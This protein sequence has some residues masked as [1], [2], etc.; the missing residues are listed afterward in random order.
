[1]I[2]RPFDS[3]MDLALFG[4]GWLVA[5]GVFAAALS[6]AL[7]SIMGSPRILQA[8]AR[9]GTFTPLQ[10]FATGS[11]KGDEPRRALV[12]T[13]LI[14]MVILL[15]AGGGG[16]GQAL[17]FVARIITMF[18]LCVNGITNLAAFVESFGLNPSFR[19][20]FRYFHWTTALAGAVGC[21]AT[22][23]LIDPRST[24]VAV[25]VL[26]YYSVHK[27]V[28]ITSCGDARRGFTYSRVRNNLIS[29]ASMPN[30]PKNWRP[31]ILVLSGAPEYRR[32]QVMYAEWLAGSRGI[33]TL[34]EILVGD[35]R[36]EHEHRKR[37]LRHLQEFIDAN[38]ISAFPE[39]VVA[40]D[41]DEG[42][43]ILLQA[44]SIGPIKPNIVILGLPR[45]AARIPPVTRHLEAIANLEMSFILLH[46]RG[47]PPARASKRIDL[48]WRGQRNGSLM[49]ILAHLLTNN[50]EW[51]QA[52]IR[53]L[54]QVT[55]EAERRA[56]EEEL[57]QLVVAGRITAQ[58]EV[59]VSQ[60]PFTQTLLEHSRSASVVMLGMG[61]PSLEQM[62]TFHKSLEQIRESLP[63][64]LFVYSAGQADLFA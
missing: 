20:R 61:R 17:N 23:L 52:T 39:V 57:N 8:L 43:S 15:S 27:R 45:D 42:L 19:P 54:R 10:Y 36:E 55:D 12:L 33:V 14:G 1:L 44:H 25:L 35:V 6:S 31:T 58:V 40:S 18:F 13:F 7:G 5:A 32:T 51:R 53:V 63:T 56:A 46:D 41:F 37:E 59:I 28:L 62:Q 30:H 64:T 49:L 29:L 22:A 24:A 50:W 60:K 11:R 3:L 48:W 34:A 16:G 4:A 47:W 38:G 26:L 21:G 2:E 9:D